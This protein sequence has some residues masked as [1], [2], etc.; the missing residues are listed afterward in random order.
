MQWNVFICHASEDK[1][2]VVQPLATACEKAGISC[3]LDKEQINWGDSITQ[4]INHGLASAEFVVVVLSDSFLAKNWPQ[5]EL[6]AVQNIEASSGKIRIL[7]LLVGGNTTCKKILEKLPLL[8]DKSY[9]RWNGDVGEVISALLKRLGRGP[10][11]G[12]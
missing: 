4:R 10:P 2:D 6:D 8:N 11:G 12:E 9:L 5:R 1:T 3:W 7:P